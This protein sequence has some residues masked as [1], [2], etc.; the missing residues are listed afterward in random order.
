ME[1][2]C[3]G[4]LCDLDGYCVTLYKLAFKDI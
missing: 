2:D 3:I 4:E 1:C